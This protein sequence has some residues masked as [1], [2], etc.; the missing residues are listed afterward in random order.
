MEGRDC[1]AVGFAAQ[2][3]Q[4]QGTVNHQVLHG[5]HGERAVLEFATDGEPGDDGNAEAS[6]DGALDRLGACEGE[7]GADREAAF[8]QRLLDDGAGAGA[9]LAQDE[10]LAAELAPRAVT[11][12][13]ASSGCLRGAMAMSSSLPEYPGVQALVFHRALGEA[14]LDQ[15]VH[16]TLLDGFGVGDIELEFDAGMAAVEFAEYLRQQIITDRHARAHGEASALEPAK[17]P[18]GAARLL[19]QRRH[20]LRVLGEDFA[21]LGEAGAAGEAFEKTEFQ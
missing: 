8:A 14:D 7:D 11:F 13:R 2:F 16:E 3:L 21:A 19:L 4:M 6:D 5:D 9:F 15:A 17:F 12:S 1:G 20:A 10:G 18:D